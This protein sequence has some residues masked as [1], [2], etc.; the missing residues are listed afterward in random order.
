MVE[1]ELVYYRS[2][3]RLVIAKWFF[4]E[5]GDVDGESASSVSENLFNVNKFK[6][7]E[8]NVFNFLSSDHFY[9]QRHTI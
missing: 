2:V 3:F 7:Q 6:N 8:S 4:E 1:Y 5:G 9:K